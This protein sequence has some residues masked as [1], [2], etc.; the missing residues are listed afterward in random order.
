MCLEFWKPQLLEPSEPVQ[1]C[2]GITLKLEYD[3]TGV[4]DCATSS[5]LLGLK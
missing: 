4:S 2:T 3:A 5:D 1:T